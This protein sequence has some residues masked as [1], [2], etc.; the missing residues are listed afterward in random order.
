MTCQTYLKKFKNSV[1]V[2]E[3]SGGAIGKE[4]KLIEEALTN[5]NPPIVGV[6]TDAHRKDAEAFSRDTCLAIA[7]LLG[8]DRP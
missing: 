6:P 3:H 7:F 5:K 2:I 4:P 1:E 8:S